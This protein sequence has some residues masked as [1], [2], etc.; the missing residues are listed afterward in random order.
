MLFLQTFM[1]NLVLTKSLGTKHHVVAFTAAIFL[2][3]SRWVGPIKQSEC[4]FSFYLVIVGL[5]EF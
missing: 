5:T 2:P 1:T 3:V 4:L